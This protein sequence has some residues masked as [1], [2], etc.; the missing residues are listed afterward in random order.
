MG[1]FLSDSPPPSDEPVKISADETFVNRFVDTP[2]SGQSRPS[3]ETEG[4]DDV[5]DSYL[6]R[7]PVPFLSEAAI[8]ETQKEKE[9]LK[10]LEELQERESKAAEKKVD[11]ISKRSLRYEPLPKPCAGERQRVLQCYRANQ[12]D[13]LKCAQVVERYTQCARRA[14]AGVTGRL[15]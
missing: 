2:G 15:G 3:E 13:V 5:D 10:L 8:P 1:S 12:T 14:A 6:Q 9:R 11:E 4:A 7:P